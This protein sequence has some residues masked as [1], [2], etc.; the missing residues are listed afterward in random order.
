MKKFL[1]ICTLILMAISQTMGNTPQ[2]R[3]VLI[4]EFTNT[5]CGP[6]A[7][8]SPILDKAIYDRLGDCIA[9]KYHS[10]YPY[11][12][13]EF[14]LYDRESQQAKLS[15][16]GVSGVP[17]T[18][19]D[20]IELSERSYPFLNQLI[21]WCG[22]QVQNYDLTVAKE[23]TG[24]Q[25][26]VHVQATPRLNAD[27]TNVRLFVAAIEEHIQSATP[28][29]N[30]ETELNYTMR[31]M[32]TPANGHNW[33]ETLA[34]GQAYNF[35][36]S[37]TIDFFN[38]VKQ[39]GVV[40]F[41]QDMSTHSILAT[42]YVGPDAEVENKLTLIDVI[43]T[44][45]LICT[46]E[47]H[48]K[49]V[50]RNDGAQTLT[51]ATLNVKVNGSVKQY[52]WEG[53]LNYL[54]RDTMAFSNFAGFMLAADGKN[55]AEIWFSD[56][57][58]SDAVSGVKTLTFSNSVQ[59]K[60]SVLLKIYTDKKPEEITWSVY[61]SAGDI[62]QQGG[63]YT[64]ARKFINEQLNLTADDCYQLEFYDAGGDGIKGAAGNGYYQ[65]MQVD[66]AGKST[67]ITQG[68][69]DNALHVV[70]F[71]LD[72]T[73][74]QEQQLV[75]F[76]EFT[77]TSCDPCAEFSPA[78]DR[79]IRERMGQMVPITYHWNFPSNKDPFY[80][81]NPTD[82]E[83]RAAY[84]GISGVPALFADGSHVGAHGHENELDDYVNYFL[85]ISPK[86]RLST[87]AVLSD[88]GQLTA[89]ARLV[90]KEAGDGSNWRLFV[91][92]VEERIEWEEPAPNG[93]RSWNYVM[94]KMLPS[95]E[96]QP[97]E[98]A[99]QAL[100]PYY[101]TFTWP[102]TGYTDPQQLGLVTFVQDVTTQE[103]LG[104]CYTPLPTGDRRAAKILEVQDTPNRICS[105][106]FTSKLVIRN[107]GSVTLT[108]AQINVSINGETQQTP[109]NG[110]LRPLETMTVETP[111]FTTFRLSEDGSNQVQI[112]L[113][114]LNGSDQSS[115][116]R[117][118]T[119]NNAY[120][121]A[122]AVRLTLMT[123][124]HPEEIT[125]KV[126]NSAGDVVCEGG[127]YSEARKKHVIDLPLDTDDCYTLEFLDAG[128]NG[129]TGDNGRGYYMLHEVSAEGKTR[130]LV[131]GDYTTATHEVYFSLH[132]A[133]PT[134]IDAVT[135]N[136]PAD[137][138]R[139]AYDLQGRPANSRS[140]IVIT[141]D[142]KKTINK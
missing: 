116:L 41:L 86:V 39:L 12:E 90:A 40:A 80:L 112:W 32:I 108:N 77:N 54:Q 5:G 19:V 51:S 137:S 14:Y 66:E 139:H 10:G 7:S 37:W 8:W 42:A 95:A 73:P 35:D 141:K 61:N 94:R 79:V 127:P 75:L 69:Y 49:A 115:P 25:L 44:P 74:T 9:I 56:V 106:S 126:Y 103:I 84:Y 64:E 83:S 18:F 72:G 34:A 29:P 82:A 62:V 68:D 46:P 81:A 4:E 118:L 45:D 97:L 101:Y 71:R 15:F 20:G 52:H 91:V 57:N 117:T 125:W 107:T 104:T 109:W 96:G 123:D 93:E 140:R 124:Q 60:Y 1:L 53:D 87:E 132:N 21:S 27:G 48:G 55:E 119:I 120:S 138:H 110:T 63:P 89:R 36:G 6:C 129:I 28:F 59:A 26:S 31:K 130:L 2:K 47:F 33:G 142:K 135:A 121:A 136:D 70:H 16:Y 92:A 114:D 88:D 113:S 76:E 17:T 3:L 98:T 85:D 134:D 38:D 99:L 105:P 131:Q 111:A 100:T 11:S 22:E 122:N 13:D 58:G 43:S 78:L 50:L 67:R 65:L 24:N 102:V 133:S 30:G 128:G 23:V